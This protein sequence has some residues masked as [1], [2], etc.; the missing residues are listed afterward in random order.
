MSD[1]D[2]LADWL[3]STEGRVVRIVLGTLVILLGLG[4]V[5]GFLG[6]LMLLIGA[7]PIAS[8]AYGALLVGPLLGRDTRGRRPQD[9][10]AEERDDDDSEGEPSGGEDEDRSGEEWSAPP[11]ARAERPPGQGPRTKDL[12]ADEPSGDAQG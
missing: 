7:V 3:L 11:L 6:V 10:P 8:A 12:R 2:R 9:Q 1:R 4:L 5:G